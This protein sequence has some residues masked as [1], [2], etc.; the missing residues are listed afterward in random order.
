MPY[1]WFSFLLV[2]ISILTY[3][4]FSAWLGYYGDDWPGLYTLVS[5]G[6]ASIIEHTSV[7]RPFWGA[8]VGGVH[9][10]L[11]DWPL[12][13]QVYAI[14]TRWLSA[15]AFF[16]L[17]TLLWPS[18]IREVSIIAILFVVYPGMLQVSKAFTY[19]TIWLQL[20]ICL[21][22]FALM[23][24]VAKQNTTGYKLTFV[25]IVFAVANWNI[26]EYFLGLEALRPILL[27]TI[28]SQGT[29]R[30]PITLMLKVWVPYLAALAIYFLY[31]IFWSTT[32]RTEVDPRLYLLQ[33]LTNPNDSI[34]RML[35]KVVPDIVEISVLSWSQVI[36]PSMAEFSAPSILFCWIVGVTAG[37]FVFLYFYF[38]KKRTE[39]SYKSSILESD[40]NRWSSAVATIG[41]L[42]I[43]FGMVPVWFSGQHYELSD[44]YGASRYALSGMVGA[45]ILFYSLIHWIVRNE[46]FRL[47]L[48]IVVI[49]SSVAI[50]VKSAHSFREEWRDQK[51]T[52]WQITWRIPELR[53][54][55]TIWL[56]S[57]DWREGHP[58]DTTYSMPINIIY[59]SKG[60]SKNLDYWVTRVEIGDSFISN[61]KRVD[62]TTYHV[63]NDLEFTGSV[64]ESVVIMH[65]RPSCLK[66]LSSDDLYSSQV[67]ESMQELIEIS[68]V[69]LIGRSSHRDN[70]LPRE[71][72]GKEPEHDWCYFFQKADLARQFNDWE[73]IVDIGDKAISLGLKPK[74]KNE[75][76][77][78][79]DA[80]K[81]V[82]RL[83]DIEWLN[84][85]FDL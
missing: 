31:R 12:A 26:N 85:M 17:L 49:S 2:V 55:T 56:Q 7:D 82:G 36:H 11:G 24:L 38:L 68:N 6:Y 15:I 28:I 67:V 3:G 5:G 45:P 37:I 74:N 41:L 33:F 62:N 76:L 8:I 71:I 14:A 34:I 63:A 44:G 80:Y 39:T 42:A 29:R 83:N 59:S 40:D 30:Q 50:H 4:L 58:G 54:G 84:N 35:E 1:R 69:D 64:R 16:W 52:L 25:S 10:I 46:N 47:F 66:V 78:F 65:S 27:W 70:T 72:F 19:G 53:P 81:R 57:D 73:E 9:A 79:I 77:L 48:V 23:L 43:C 13:W 32:T 51:D 22:S 20:T 18:R 75:W 21:I 60:T 61:Q